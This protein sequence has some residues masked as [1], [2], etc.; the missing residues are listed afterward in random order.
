MPATHGCDD[1]V[2]IRKKAGHGR[3]YAALVSEFVQD[4]LHDLLGQRWHI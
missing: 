3:L 4:V 1:A 2:R